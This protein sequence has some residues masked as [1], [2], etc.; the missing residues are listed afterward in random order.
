MAVVL[1]S[2]NTFDREGFRVLMQSIYPNGP[3][4][5]AGDPEPF[6]GPHMGKPANQITMNVERVQT[7]GTEDVWKNYD[8]ATD[9]N[10]IVYSNA[11]VY[12][13]S[14]RLISYS[15]DFPAYDQLRQFCVRLRRQSVLLGLN[16]LDLGYARHDSIID[17]P[18]TADQR[19]LYAAIV[20]VQFNGLTLESDESSG[21]GVIETINGWSGPVGG[22][23]ST[24]ALPG[25]LTLPGE[26]S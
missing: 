16:Q 5:W 2:F 17:L 12:N 24:G 1:Y 22:S 13:I 26:S 19:E 15:T 11:C 9:S 14:F 3:V 23:G 25:T 10:E 7:L 6:P 21:G 4:I 20:E 18:V 8:A